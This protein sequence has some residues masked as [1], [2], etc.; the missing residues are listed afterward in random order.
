MD[1]IRDIIQKLFYEDRLTFKNL[2][3]HIQTDDRMTDMQRKGR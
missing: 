1:I 2:E 3:K